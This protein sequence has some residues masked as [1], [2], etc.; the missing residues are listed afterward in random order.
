MM[1]EPFLARVAEHV[2]KHG[3]GSPENLAV[4]L[5]SQRA[6]V[7]FRQHFSRI[8]PEIQF[9]PQL[10][11]LDQLVSGCTA[12]QSA[13][14]IELLFQL[15][16]SYTEVW[17]ADAEPFDRF[18]KWASLALADFSE[19]DA[20][21]ID[22]KAFFRDLTNLEELDAWSLNEPDLTTTQQQY[23]WFW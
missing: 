14:S 20:Y 7:Y 5:P 15:Y 18:L 16:Q 12:L 11:T 4:V 3:S 9:A 8:V 2:L 22:P 23:A 10:L 21:L 13:D 6:A 1:T 19:V 17:Q